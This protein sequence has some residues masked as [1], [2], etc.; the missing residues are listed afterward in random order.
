MRYASRGVTPL[1]VYLLLGT[2][3]SD[4]ER[5]RRAGEHHRDME[6]SRGLFGKE[7]VWLEL[8]LRQGGNKAKLCIITAGTERS[9]SPVHFDLLAANGDP[10]KSFQTWKGVCIPLARR[11]AVLAGLFLPQN[12]ASIWWVPITV[13]MKKNNSDPK[14]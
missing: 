7:A 3:N 6:S 11:S 5:R 13:D 12:P 9:S 10:V 4:L 14:V 2:A 8:N 1:R